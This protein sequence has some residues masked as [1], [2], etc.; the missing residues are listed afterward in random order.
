V[1]WAFPGP[2]RNCTFLLTPD[3]IDSPSCHF[4]N[5]VLEVVDVVRGRPARDLNRLLQEL[6]GG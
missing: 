1:V 2:R 4:G 6:T 3:D 5:E